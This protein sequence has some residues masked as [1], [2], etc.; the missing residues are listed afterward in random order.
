MSTWF[1]VI[2]AFVQPVVGAL[3]ALILVIFAGLL[4]LLGLLCDESKRDY[5]L[6][7]ADHF[8]RLATVLVGAMQP[9]S[10]KHDVDRPPENGPCTE[11]GS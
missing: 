4:G 1:S 3:P 5:A 2:K 8:T 7:Y 11:P 9:T 6:T 10:A